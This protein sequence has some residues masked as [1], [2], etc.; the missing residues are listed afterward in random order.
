MDE[1]DM[2]RAMSL[3]GLRALPRAAGMLTGAIV[4]VIT[5]NATLALLVSLV[6]WFVVYLIKSTLSPT[7]VDT[8]LWSVIGIP[9][10][11]IGAKTIRWFLF[12]TINIIALARGA[13]LN[14]MLGSMGLLFLY[15]LYIVI[16]RR[17]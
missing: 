8:Y 1:H 5:L 9:I 4:L 10:N 7:I 17:A 2:V 6:V 11:A 16:T 14:E 15:D 12:W 3:L 13:N